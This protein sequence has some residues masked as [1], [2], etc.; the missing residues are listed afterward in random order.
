MS[1]SLYENIKKSALKPGSL[2]TIFSALDVKRSKILQK[3]NKRDCFCLYSWFHFCGVSHAKTDL[4]NKYMI[5]LCVLLIYWT[6]SS[7]KLIILGVHEKRWPKCARIS[8]QKL[9][10]PKIFSNFDWFLILIFKWKKKHRETGLISEKTEVLKIEIN[11]RVEAAISGCSA[12][13]SF[14]QCIC[15][16]LVAKNH[17]KCCSRCLVHKF[18]FTV[19][20]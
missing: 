14:L 6:R 3:L 11:E 8:K 13:G 9:K 16:V 4:H 17:Q 20:F 7:I 1:C 5:W 15:S 10:Y 19:N 18:S 2:H 12:T